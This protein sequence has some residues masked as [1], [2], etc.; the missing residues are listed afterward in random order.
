[1]ECIEAKVS[2]KSGFQSHLVF[3]RI[4]NDMD[5]VQLG[6]QSECPWVKMLDNEH[7]GL[8]TA[9]SLGLADSCYF[10]NV[11][12]NY[13][14]FLPRGTYYKYSTVHILLHSFNDRNW[15]LYIN[16]AY[17]LAKE[18]GQAVV[19]FPMAFHISRIPCQWVNGVKAIADESSRSIESQIKATKYAIANHFA[20]LPLRYLKAVHQTAED[21]MLLKSHIAEGRLMYFTSDA[22]VRVKGYGTGALIAESIQHAYAHQF[23]SPEDFSTHDKEVFITGYAS[24]DAIKQYYQHSFY[25]DI[26]DNGFLKTLIHENPICQYFYENI[27]K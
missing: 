17:K 24:L 20:E 27:K 26:L 8:D 13:P 19:L 16:K 23:E 22:R 3:Q 14:V 15:D 7:F 25:D 18:T 9:L 21:V 11:E 6:F 10:S 4:N 2:K 12:F 5:V 1:M